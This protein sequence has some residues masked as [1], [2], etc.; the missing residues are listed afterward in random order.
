MDLQCLDKLSVILLGTS[1]V[2][3]IFNYESDRL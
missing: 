2:K 3:F 1:S